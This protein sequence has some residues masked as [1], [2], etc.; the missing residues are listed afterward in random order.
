MKITIKRT[1]NESILSFQERVF[2]ILGI[3]KINNY[4]A[5]ISAKG[6]EIIPFNKIL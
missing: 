4:T 2:K 6:I 3:W 1:E 5:I